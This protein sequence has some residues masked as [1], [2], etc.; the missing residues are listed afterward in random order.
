MQT[1]RSLQNQPE[2]DAASI[3]ERML[4]KPPDVK[5]AGLSEAVVASWKETNG[6]L[7]D[8]SVVR[9]GAS[10]LVQ[11]AP[12]DR[13][14]TWSGHDHQRW[15]LHVLEQVDDQIA[16][17]TMPRALTVSAPR[18][19]LH[20]DAVQIRAEDFLTSAHNRHA[21]EH[22]R[23]ETV[24]TRVAQIGTDIRRATHASDEVEGTVLQRAGTWISN[25][26]REARFHARAF[27]FD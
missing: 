27:L 16:R 4:A 15:I 21:V 5:P 18:I 14:L 6:T 8:G 22:V 23:T 11:P 26:F 2:N 10:C 24:N 13:V 25:T 12:G 17:I 9:L 19:A 3:L 1:L 7:A 20:A